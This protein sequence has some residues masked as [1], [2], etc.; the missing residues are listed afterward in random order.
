[1]PT[2][3]FIDGQ[4][5][6]VGKSLFAR[7][8]IHYFQDNSL[9]YTLV[10]ADT[11]SDVA[12]VYEGITDINFNVSDAATA[13]SS[14]KAADV[15][16]I[17]SLAFEKSVIVNLPANVHEQV[18]YWIKDNDLLEIGKTEG[19][20]MYKWFLCSGSYDSVSMFLESLKT[21]EGKLP[22]I[23]VRN[24]GL[25]PDWSNADARAE[26]IKA[27]EQ[28]KFKE[29]QFPGLRFTE[30]DYLEEN[31]IPFSMAL[32]NKNG[33]PVLSR[34]RLVKFLRC[35]SKAVSDVEVVSQTVPLNS[36]PNTRQK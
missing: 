4:K 11:N 17:F 21:F 5:G 26:L 2:I 18:A 23:F 1:M 9:P 10:D 34:Q 13:M 22:H 8:L 20:D 7:C 30:R 33:M 16:R 6:G 19:I 25:C 14:K 31:R 27:K 15:D 32:D 28:Y 3:H 24:L 29:L 12:E 35:T 36:E